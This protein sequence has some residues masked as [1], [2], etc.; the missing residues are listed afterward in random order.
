MSELLDLRQEA[1]KARDTVWFLHS[2]E[3]VERTDITLSLRLHIRPSL[4]VQIF[5]GEQSNALY[6]ALIE[7]GRRI[8]YGVDR[9]RH[10]WHMHPHGDAERHV[11]LSEGLTPRPILTFLAQVEEILLQNE[12]I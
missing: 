5:C 12:M 3:E 4:F 8:I 2:L 10:G 7:G 9:D 6:M 11:P 1:Q